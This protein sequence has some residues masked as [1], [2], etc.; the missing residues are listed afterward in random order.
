MATPTTA[1]QRQ[2]LILA[3]FANTNWLTGPGY[4]L[5]LLNYTNPNAQRGWLESTL[6]SGALSPSACCC[7]MA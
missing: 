2:H 7:P 1:I 4:A 5:H 3:G 6:S